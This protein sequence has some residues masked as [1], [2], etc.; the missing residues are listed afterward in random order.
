MQFSINPY[1]YHWEAAHFNR[2]VFEDVHE[3]HETNKRRKREINYNHHSPHYGSTNVVEFT[4]KVHDREFHI[5]MKED[6]TSVFASDFL[7]EDSNGPIDYD[8]SRV[9]TG[10]LK[11]DENS[12]VHGVLT[13]DK[14]FDGTIVTSTEHYYIEPAHRYSEKLSQSGIHTIIYKLSDVNLNAHNQKNIN[15]L[16]N[17]SDHEMHCA[18]EKLHRKLT[19]HPNQFLNDEKGKRIKRWLQVKLLFYLFIHCLSLYISFIVTG[20]A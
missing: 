12:H 8:I 11:D 7:I 19:N 1:I 5:K 18:S 2:D 20:R 16:T 14:L 9:Y 13:R 3:K 17:K 4:I 15:P 10:H 6:P